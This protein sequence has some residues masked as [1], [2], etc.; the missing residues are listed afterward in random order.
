MSERGEA[1]VRAVGLV[2]HRER[3]RAH[4]LAQSSV[5]W[6]VAHGVEVRVPKADALA[7]GLDAYAVEPDKFAAGLDLV[8][9]FGGDGTMLYT[10]QLVYP[11]PVPIIGVNVGQLAYLSEIEPDELD[12]ALPRLLAKQFQVSERMVLE[13]DVESS[14]GAAGTRYALNEAVLEKQRT[15]HMIRLDVSINGSQFTSYAADGLIIATPTG[16]TAYSFSARGPIASPAL[17]CTVLTPISPHML[18]DRSLV[19][20]EHEELEFL[21]CDGRSAELTIDGREL[22]PLAD[23]DRVRCRAAA[24][25]LRLATIHPRDF[26]QILKLKFALPDR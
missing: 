6:L 20:E 14:T 26:H 10:V 8:I 5:D 22:G 12:A 17:R 21:V 25:P 2:P 16:T 23:G 4:A 9:S 19:L 11:A 1:G 15:G 13:V 18:F 24:E 7:A 3:G